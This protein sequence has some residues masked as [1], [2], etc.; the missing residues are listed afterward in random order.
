MCC[1]E[2]PSWAI[3]TFFQ[4]FLFTTSQDFCSSGLKEVSRLEDHVI[5]TVY[6]LYSMQQATWRISYQKEV[7]KISMDVQSV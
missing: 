7:D 1:I 4:P 3:R 6:S 2:T 5:N